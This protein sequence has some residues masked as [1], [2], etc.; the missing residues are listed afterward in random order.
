MVM[1]VRQIF[2]E[3]KTSELIVGGNSPYNSRS[4]KIREM[5]VGRASR[6]VRNGAGDIRDTEWSTG[7]CE[8]FDDRLA[9]RRVALVDATQM[10]FHELVQGSKR[11]VGAARREVVSP[12]SEYGHAFLSVEFMVYLSCNETQSQ[13]T[14]LS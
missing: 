4:L 1:M 9:T 5:T 8:K 6:H 2:G 13:Y 11:R 12:R 7:G 3:F 10:N 14:L